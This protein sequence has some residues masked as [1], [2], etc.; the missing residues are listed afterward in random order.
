[1]ADDKTVSLR[2]DG[3]Q[4]ED[5]L[6]G[7]ERAA[8]GAAEAMGK[9]DTE[10]KQAEGAAKGLGDAAKGAADKVG[11]LGAE[12]KKTEENTKRLGGTNRDY[13]SAVRNVG[14]SIQNITRLEAA[15]RASLNDTGNSEKVR[16]A[17]MTAVMAR[18]IG[19]AADEARAMEMLGRGRRDAAEAIRFVIQ[20]GGALPGTMHNAAAAAGVA[21]ARYRNLGNVAQQA[22]WQI[23]DVAAVAAA[24]GNVMATAGTQLGQ[25]MGAFGP[26][27]AAAGAAVTVAGALAA[28]MTKDADAAK[29]A[30]EA[31]KA[32]AAALDGATPIFERFKQAQDKA[33]GKAEHWREERDAVSALRYQ[34]DELLL[35]RE[36]MVKNTNFF[37]TNLS[38]APST[39]D[40]RDI[41]LKIANLRSALIQAQKTPIQTRAITAAETVFTS[42]DSLRELQ[43]KQ[44]DLK[45]GID[46]AKTEG[47]AAAVKSLTAAYNAV[48]RAVDTY[49]TEGQREV[50]MAEAKAKASAMNKTEAQHYLALRSAEIGL[51]GKVIEIGELER[52]QKATSIEANAAAAKSYTESQKA[53]SAAAIGTQ[54][55][56]AQNSLDVE[57]Q[58]LAQRRALGEISAAEEL[59]LAIAIED[60]KRAVAMQE[61]QQRLALLRRTVGIEKTEIAAAEDAITTLRAKHSLERIKQVDAELAARQAAAKQL[62]QIDIK[63]NADKGMDDVAAREENLSFNK[64][65]GNIGGAEEIAELRAIAEEKIRIRREEL[66]ATLRLAGLEDAER[67]RI[68]AELIGLERPRT[69]DMSKI[70]RQATQSRLQEISAWTEPFKSAVNS[71][72]TGFIQGTLTKRR[73]AAQ[74]AQSI[75]A[76]YLGKF[77][78]IATDAFNKHVLMA[79]WDRTFGAQEVATTVAKEGAKSRAVAVGQ[80]QQTA[81]TRVGSTQRAI[82]GSTEDAGF[83]ARVGRQIAEWFGMESAKTGATITG[84]GVRTGVTATGA[85]AREG[86][87]MAQTTSSVGQSAAR[88]AAGTYADVSEHVPYGWLV[89]PAM[90]AA[91]FV[92]I[93][94]FSSRGG[95]AEV[96]GDGLLYTLHAKETVLP[97]AYAVPLRNAL[98]SGALS[99]KAAT[100]E[101]V[102][103]AMSAL[104]SA[105]PS[106]SRNAAAIATMAAGNLGIPSVGSFGLPDWLRKGP[107]FEGAR[108]STTNNVTKGGDTHVTVP[109]TINIH[110]LDGASVRRVLMS[111]PDA[112]SG[113]MQKAVQNG[114][115]SAL[116]VTR[117]R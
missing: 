68:N 53:M 81:A 103:S 3:S 107:D 78:T 45:A 22:G 58:A 5:A 86:V 85:A 93:K 13:N 64:A 57:R 117:K 106:L 8:E 1:M 62:A 36:E 17:A 111:N 32:Y 72:V 4:P 79:L 46:Q 42:D 41:D 54:A 7:I 52:R 83:F 114:I 27:G 19:G 73:A 89:A 50:L 48:T 76:S 2:V 49:V 105:G 6:K 75:A 43:T 9:L 60:R 94:A 10:I 116:Y 102:Q 30:E 63:D 74:A 21:G 65:M 97:A 56:L 26:G 59:A 66:E 80:A 34:L 24:G 112:V 71:T 84:E 44:A 18:T 87:D 110:A 29:R 99:G 109:T 47:N 35:K 90:A 100:P 98:S 12:V 51:M 82:A 88:G 15:W 92:A 23:S 108:N 20:H 67:R 14:D 33:G 61:A 104:M 69:L 38:F 70:D 96:P 91:A 39:D 37:R 113:A 40:F 28:A 115:A 77:A 101:H 16:A 55:H 31:V 11:T 95:E 25:F